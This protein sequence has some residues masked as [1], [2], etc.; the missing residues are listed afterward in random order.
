MLATEWRIM[1]RKKLKNVG[2][3]GDWTARDKE[4]KAADPKGSWKAR[5]AAVDAE[6]GEELVPLRSELERLRPKFEAQLR[7]AV[8][9][10]KMDRAVSKAVDKRVAYE[11]AR[12]AKRSKDEAV[13]D[14]AADADVVAPIAGYGNDRGG[15]GPLGI[16]AEVPDHW[17]RRTNQSERSDLAWALNHLSVGVVEHDAPTA[18]AWAYLQIGRMEPKSFMERAMPHVLPKREQD[19]STLRFEDDSRDLLKELSDFAMLCES[20]AGVGSEF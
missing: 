4:L 15:V 12:R 19:E 18:A 1:R 20:R 5:E 2:R 14:S 6:F 16:V 7:L 3:L 9:A 10:L 11:V 13:G 17:R 8:P